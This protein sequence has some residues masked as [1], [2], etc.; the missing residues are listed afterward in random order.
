MSMTIENMHVSEYIYVKLRMS[1][2]GHTKLI[3][4]T[5]M[6]RKLS[7]DTNPKAFA[8]TCLDQIKYIHP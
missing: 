4:L 8:C 6:L 1:S 5:H 7:T 3:L 2:L